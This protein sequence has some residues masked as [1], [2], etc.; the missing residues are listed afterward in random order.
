[1][2]CAIQMFQK[3]INSTQT[4]KS[5]C[6]LVPDVCSTLYFQEFWSLLVNKH[7]YHS[8]LNILHLLQDTLSL[9]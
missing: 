4:I 9:N 2:E 3:K 1:M 5:I 7:S 6:I 8:P